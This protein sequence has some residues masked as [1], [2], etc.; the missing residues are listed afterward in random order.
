MVSLLTPIS[1]SSYP[2]PAHSPRPPLQ[3]YTLMKRDSYSRFLKSQ[4][5][6]SVMM[7]ALASPAG[8]NPPSCRNPAMTTG[9]STDSIDRL[10]FK[11]GPQGPGGRAKGPGI[12]LSFAKFA[13]NT[14]KKKKVAGGLSTAATT[15]STVTAA[16][17]DDNRRK[18]LLPWKRSLYFCYF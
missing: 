4:L 3:I 1:P 9:L 13:A 18:S 7:D 11:G 17:S 2:N 8:K 5:Y 14:M 16:T 12:S 6:R 15:T 10:V